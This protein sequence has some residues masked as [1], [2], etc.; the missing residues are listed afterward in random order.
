[1]THETRSLLWKAI[2]APILDRMSALRCRAE[3]SGLAP[4]ER[5]ELAGM[6]LE[7]R[8]MFAE[9]RRNTRENPR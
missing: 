7:L 3:D 2:S 5:A 1:M 6:E 9:F 4:E 8:M